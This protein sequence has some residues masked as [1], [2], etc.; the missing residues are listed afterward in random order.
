[1]INRSLEEALRSDLEFNPLLCQ[2][3]PSSMYGPK[4]TDRERFSFGPT[5]QCGVEVGQA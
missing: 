5:S 4:G 1:M 3:L 2:P